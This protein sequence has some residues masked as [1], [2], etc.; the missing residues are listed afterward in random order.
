MAVAATVAVD[1]VVAEPF[2]VVSIVVVA[3]VV[4]V[5]VGAVVV[6]A[7]ASPTIPLVVHHLARPVDYLTVV[8][9]LS[10]YFVE[11]IE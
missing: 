11:A 6:V 8:N 9:C 1:V 10:Y 4:V 7:Y 5:V 3:A 2:A